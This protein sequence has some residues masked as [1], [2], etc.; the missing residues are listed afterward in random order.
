MGMDPPNRW[1]VSSMVNG[2]C[3]IVVLISA[4]LEWASFAPLAGRPVLG[5]MG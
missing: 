1:H 3:C 4:S 5:G 2:S